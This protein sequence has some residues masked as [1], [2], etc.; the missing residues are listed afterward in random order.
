MYR[1]SETARRRRARVTACSLL[2]LVALAG[3]ACRQD[4]HDQ[5]RFEPLETN[6]FF[7]DGKA[8]RPKI[9]GTVARGQ[10]RLDDHL[11]AGRDDAGQ[12]VTSFPF[13]ID[14]AALDRGEERFNIFCSVCH[15]RTGSGNG[16]VV[17]RGFKRPPSLHEQRL[18]DA[19]V[20]YLFDV[21]TNGYGNMPDYRSQIPTEDRWRIVAYLRAL[22]L[23][24]NASPDDV[25]ADQRSLLITSHED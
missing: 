13:A 2:L 22:Q 19:Q 10:L 24:Q 1:S 4:M 17:Q 5:P 3:A 14:A 23:S 8:S 12:W 7:D 9:E 11:H 15:D 21:I 6:P 16:M 25:P 18:R 20:G